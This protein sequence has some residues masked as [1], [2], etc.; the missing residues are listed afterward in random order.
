MTD[1]MTDEQLRELLMATPNPTEGRAAIS[2]LLA[3]R[4]RVEQLEAALKRIAQ[5]DPDAGPINFAEAIDT[6]YA[7]LWTRERLASKP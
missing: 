6:A 3:L 1:R 4:A 2:E 7:A 5:M